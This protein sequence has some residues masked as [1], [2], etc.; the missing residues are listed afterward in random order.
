AGRIAGGSL[1][2][3]AIPS[4]RA[5]VIRI[6]LRGVRIRAIDSVVDCRPSRIGRRRR[7]D[8]APIGVND[9]GDVQPGR[10]ESRYWDLGGLDGGGRADRARPGRMAAGALLVGLGVLNQ[11]AA[12]RGRSHRPGLA[13]TVK[14]ESK[15]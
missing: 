8:G 7:V 3:K 1:W 11:C 14:P 2:A 6:G 13:P 10:T 4:Y 9:H 12:D 5:D 15:R